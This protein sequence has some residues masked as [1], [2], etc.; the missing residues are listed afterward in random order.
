VLYAGAAIVF[1]QILTGGAALSDI[2]P[3]KVAGF[4]SLVTAAAAGALAFIVQEKVTPTEDVEAFVN[5]AG[6]TVA[7][8]A[9]LIPNGDPVTVAP[10]VEGP[11]D[12]RPMREPA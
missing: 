6:R 1:M 8:D 9:S 2:I 3:V 7:G 12:E 10:A 4:L 5:M 11:W